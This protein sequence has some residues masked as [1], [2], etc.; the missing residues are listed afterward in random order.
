MQDIVDMLQALPHA[1][2]ASPSGPS[3]RPGRTWQRPMSR[4]GT[5][6]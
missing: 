5:A 6:P 1:I 3:G 2:L 4:A